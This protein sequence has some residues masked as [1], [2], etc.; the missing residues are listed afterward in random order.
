MKAKR[1]HRVPLSKQALEM[2]EQARLLNPKSALVFPGQNGRSV[3]AGSSLTRALA[4]TG[5]KS[6]VHGM[7]ST[8]RRWAEEAGMP[9]DA[10]EFSIAHVEGSITKR[11]YQRSDLLD[12]RRDWVQA[13]ADAIS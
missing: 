10:A 11:A 12:Q 13:W 4:A 2:L 9:D 3:L 6:K 8:F 1:E 5:S 7:R